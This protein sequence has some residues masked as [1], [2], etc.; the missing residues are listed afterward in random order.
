[1]GGDVGGGAVSAIGCPVVGVETIEGR[2]PRG[3]AGDG[4]AER[5]LLAGGDHRGSDES[6]GADDDR[7]TC[8]GG[9]RRVDRDVDE[10]ARADDELGLRRAA[11]P[12]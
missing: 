5:R 2:Q 9:C 12:R 7:A 11:E 8:T 4:S 1:M 6:V 3:E 10:P